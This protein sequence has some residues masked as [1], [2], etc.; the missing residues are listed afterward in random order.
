MGL[1]FLKYSVLKLI[2]PI[3]TTGS[4]L[5]KFLISLINLQKSN[6]LAWLFIMQ[7]FIQTY[8]IFKELVILQI[9]KLF[10]ITT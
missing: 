1:H 3:T 9:V 5:P 8:I 6:Y 10:F 2:I 7:K 4:S